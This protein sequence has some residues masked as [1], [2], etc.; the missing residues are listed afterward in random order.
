MNKKEWSVEDKKTVSF[1]LDKTHVLYVS[2]RRGF[3]ELK[4]FDEDPE[5]N[6]PLIVYTKRIYDKG[7]GYL[8]NR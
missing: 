3:I 4:V 2:R 1:P 6:K 7:L 5:L 8:K